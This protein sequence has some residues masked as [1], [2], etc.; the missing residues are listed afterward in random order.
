MRLKWRIF[1]V[2]LNNKALVS[3]I[4][5]NKLSYFTVSTR[6][7]HIFAAPKVL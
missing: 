6:K 2:A 7:I 4:Q 3:A 5:L 1:C